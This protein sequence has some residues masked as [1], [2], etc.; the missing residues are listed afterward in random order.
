MEVKQAACEK[1]ACFT[2]NVKIFELIEIVKNLT[3]LDLIAFF[4]TLELP[5][6]ALQF[7]MRLTNKTKC[8][9]RF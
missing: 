6:R 8:V 4:T 7:S 1:N 9:N 2:S 3:P 5:I